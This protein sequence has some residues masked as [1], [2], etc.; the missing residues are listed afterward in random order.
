M[1]QLYSVISLQTGVAQPLQVN[2]RKVVSGIRKSPIVGPVQ[3]NKL[4]LVGDEQ[5]DLT[6]H[7]GV[8][9][10]VYAYPS[11]HYAFWRA[12]RNKLGLSTSL[13]YG[14]LGENLTL[15]GLLE[16][17]LFVGDELHFPDCILRVTQPREPCSKLNAVMEDRKAAKK[18]LQ[19]GF[20]GFYL[21]VDSI[22]TIAAGQSFQ[23]KAGLQQ[24]PIRGLLKK[25]ILK[26]R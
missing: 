18:M 3:V 26:H 2:D 11:E 17:D 14:A 9:K 7:G 4:G 6:V 13:G 1:N 21:A 24:M 10:A 8:T 19:T 12:E 25:A 22:G 23:L 15:S 20:C 5:V 16:D